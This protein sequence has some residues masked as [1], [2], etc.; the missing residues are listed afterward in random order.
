[1]LERNQRKKVYQK[2][3]QIKRK[4]HDRCRSYS[5]TCIIQKSNHLNKFCSCFRSFLNS[6][7]TNM[8]GTQVRCWP[9]TTSENVAAFWRAIHQVPLDYVSKGFPN[10]WEFICRPRYSKPTKQEGFGKASVSKISDHGKDKWWMATH[11]TCEYRQRHCFQGH[12]AQKR[13]KQTRRASYGLPDFEVRGF[14]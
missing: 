3:L 10:N 2:R 5:E 6:S 4:L 8:L 9:F 7:W 11:D 1:M 13:S 14:V 12:L